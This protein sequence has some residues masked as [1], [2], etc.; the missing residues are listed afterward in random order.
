MTEHATDSTSTA[1][2][3][4]L[5][6]EFWRLLRAY[7][8]LS[9]NVEGDAGARSSAQSRY[10][11]N[12]LHCVLGEAGLRLVVFDGQPY[13]PGLPVRPLNAEDFAEDDGL[14]VAMTNEPTIVAG[15]RV[16]VLGSVTLDRRAEGAV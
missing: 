10:A 16:V 8:R 5:A 9:A 11:A 6:V 12:R 15:G 13:Q 3:A 4:R 14:F 2:L 1:H 7:D